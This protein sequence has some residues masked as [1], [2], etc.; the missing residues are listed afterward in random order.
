[1][2]CTVQE[3][4][5]RRLAE[6]MIEHGVGVVEVHRYSVKKIDSEYFDEGWRR[7]RDESRPRGRVHH[8]LLAALLG[9]PASRSRKASD[10]S[11]VAAVYALNVN[12]VAY[13]VYASDK[14]RARQG[15]W[16]M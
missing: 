8:L 5:G 7:R 10:R 14:K 2:L 9:L 1:M 3:R 13:L 6:L 11:L 12:G 4:G 15:D 16:R